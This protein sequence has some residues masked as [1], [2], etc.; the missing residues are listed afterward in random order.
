LARAEASPK[1]LPDTPINVPKMRL[2][3]V[4]VKWRG[5][6]IQGRSVPFDTLAVDMDL[7]NGHISLHPVT[8]GV[9]TGRITGTI[10]LD[11]VSDSA[12]HTKGEIQF[13]RVDLSRLM[14]VT[15][16]FAGEGRIGGKA[17]K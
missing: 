11:P 12:L 10:D 15:Q 1:L 17:S 13:Q 6:H 4:H 3:D 2:V 16:I 14:A 5:D 9:G 8:V 7:V